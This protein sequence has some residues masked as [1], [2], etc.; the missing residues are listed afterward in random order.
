M[1]GMSLTNRYSIA[2]LL[3][4]VLALTVAGCSEA[5]AARLRDQLLELAQ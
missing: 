3:S 2:V 1:N 5:V 4:V